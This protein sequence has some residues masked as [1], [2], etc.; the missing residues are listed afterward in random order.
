[1]GAEKLKQLLLGRNVPKDT[2][3]KVMAGDN[4]GILLRGI[5]K[6]EIRR[7]MVIAK[8][9]FCNSSCQI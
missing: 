8:P 5:D 7:G 9:G 3:M 2:S 1:M 6:T 4:A